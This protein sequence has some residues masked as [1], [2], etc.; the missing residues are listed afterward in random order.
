ML[1]ADEPLIKK[2]KIDKFFRLVTNDKKSSIWNATS[3]FLSLSE[4]KKKQL[5]N[6]I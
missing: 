4:I 2:E 1:F 6:V 5:L 3:K